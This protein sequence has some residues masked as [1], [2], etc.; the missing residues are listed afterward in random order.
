LLFLA[1]SRAWKVGAARQDNA[2]H[3]AESALVT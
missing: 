3:A 1:R 2:K